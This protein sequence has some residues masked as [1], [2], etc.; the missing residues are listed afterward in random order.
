MTPTTITPTLRACLLAMYAAPNN[1]L[2]RARGGFSVAGA[3]MFT[4]RAVR[5]LERD[6]L[7]EFDNPA[8]PASVTLTAKGRELA[9]QIAVAQSKDAAA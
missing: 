9:R 4:L 1:A 7:V 6:W 3:P 5:M 2:Q 8:F